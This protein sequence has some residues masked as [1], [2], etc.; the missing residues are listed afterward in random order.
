MGFR[1]RG[2]RIRPKGAR[3][4]ISDG[5][6]TGCIQIPPDGQPIVMMVDHQ[7][8]GGYPKI[9]TVIQADLPLLAQTLPNDPIRFRA[10]DIRQAQKILNRDTPGKSLA[11][12]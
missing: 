4:I 6:V 10:I 8:T 5:I 7:T 12:K 1:L 9:A 2:P 3:G 11:I